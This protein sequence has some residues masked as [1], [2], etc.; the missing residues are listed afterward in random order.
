MAL[1][2][3]QLYQNRLK[4][5]PQQQKTLWD[6]SINNPTQAWND[7]KTKYNITMPNI[8][9][10]SNT[11]NNP[12]NNQAS[13]TSG[14]ETLP[15]GITKVWTNYKYGS[16]LFSSLAAA[17][18][19]KN[20]ASNPW[21]WVWQWIDVN[22]PS[23]GSNPNEVIHTAPNGKQ[24]TI[25]ID[26]VTKKATFISQWGLWERTFNS[27]DEARNIIN[28]ANGWVANNSSAINQANQ[29]KASAGNIPWFQPW[30]HEPLEQ[31]EDESDEDYKMRVQ[32][33]DQYN[34]IADA[35]AYLSQFTNSQ[36]AKLWDF[37]KNMQANAKALQDKLRMET[38]NAL[39]EKQLVQAQFDAIKNE[40]DA[41][42]KKQRWQIQQMETQFLSDNKKLNELQNNYYNDLTSSVS[43]AAWGAAAWTRAQLSSLGVDEWMINTALNQ[44]NNV[45][46]DKLL[47]AKNDHINNLT[48][49]RDSYQTFYQTMINNEW[50][51]NEAQK[52]LAM[53][54]QDKLGKYDTDITKLTSDSINA[55]YKPLLDRYGN[56]MEAQNE[57]S[58][59]EAKRQETEAI[60]QAWTPVQK[61]QM[62]YDNLARAAE[63]QSANF[64]Y[65][66]VS[67][68]ILK[69]AAKM[70][71]FT[72][73]LQYIVRRAAWYKD[74]TWET[75]NIIDAVKAYI[76]PKAKVNTNTA[77]NPASNSN[78]E[79]ASPSTETSTPTTPVK[80]EVIVENPKPVVEEK[81][82][83]VQNAEVFAWAV[84]Q[85]NKRVEIPAPVLQWNRKQPS[86]LFTPDQI[87][88]ANKLY[89]QLKPLD[90]EEADRFIK[91][92]WDRNKLIQQ[93]LDMSASWAL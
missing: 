44:V 92:W 68:E 7:F 37:T 39:R 11:N 56:A 64:K 45:Y 21:Q 23:A 14:W 24:Y 32:K 53:T 30:Y 31:G 1:T 10:G 87:L 47:T 89:K 18:A 67:I 55:Q 17:I 93:L 4:L 9:G 42:Q 38:E 20:R 82:Q 51:L 50:S 28:S 52:N 71:S 78:K 54:I 86:E 29:A 69:E 41:N 57:A 79:T 26:P 13:N 58:T 62:L 61:A 15:A 63:S 22:V 66:T 85:P 3:E 2:S 34:F 70:P 8:W 81:K 19:A 16:Q 48:K 90:K 40:F 91:A 65:D 83:Q 6:S 27:L 36:D 12:V 74:S 77:P 33:Y 72:E 35:W 25:K 46:Q 88:L 59:S 84:N 43:R 75:P 73:A 80:E 60:F 49:L 5:T 76:R